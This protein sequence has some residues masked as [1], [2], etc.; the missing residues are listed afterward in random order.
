MLTVIQ[1]FCHIIQKEFSE[2]V[3]HTPL[4]VDPSS[5][6]FSSSNLPFATFGSGWRG[7]SALEMVEG[8]GISL[9]EVQGYLR[10]GALP[11]PG[12]G[13][14]VTSAGEGEYA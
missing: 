2:I 14:K 8:S 10:A 1:D 13:T 5:F 7:V 4:E 3:S 6:Y 11:R 12:A 9:D